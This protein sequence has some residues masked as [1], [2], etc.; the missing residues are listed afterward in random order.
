MSTQRWEYKVAYNNRWERTS[1][2]GQESGPEE[3]ERNSG[4]ARRFLNEL[5]VDGW[6]LVGIEHTGRGSYY[7]F[8]RPLEDGAEPDLSVTKRAAAPEPAP[9][10]Q[11]PASSGPADSQVVTL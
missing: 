2:E 10:Q 5:G 8:K 7:V 9:S 11:P 3:G 6:E 1:I 4:Y